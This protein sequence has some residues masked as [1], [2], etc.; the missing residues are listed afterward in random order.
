M[1]ALFRRDKSRSFFNFELYAHFTNMKTDMTY[2]SQRSPT[3]NHQY[4]NDRNRSAMC[5]NDAL[6]VWIIIPVMNISI[7]QVSK[8]TL[9]LIA[10][11]SEQQSTLLRWCDVI[12]PLPPT[13]VLWN[14]QIA[15]RPC[16]ILIPK[17]FSI[18]PV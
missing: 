4:Q 17:L 13:H 11:V 10:G 8:Y 3:S 7:D 14:V 5:T 9:T 18:L 12:L 1:K 15:R 16:M 2:I 6:S